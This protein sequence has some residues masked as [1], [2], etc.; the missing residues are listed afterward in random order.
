MFESGAGGDFAT[1][2]GGRTGAAYRLDGALDHSRQTY[3]HIK[4]DLYVRAS[5]SLKA[6]DARGG[7]ALY[8]EI[9]AKYPGDSDGHGALGACLFF[10]DKCQ[11]ASAEYQ[12]SIE[13]NPCPVLT[14]WRAQTN[15]YGADTR[16]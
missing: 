1:Y 16:L 9:I 3:D 2:I 4:S 13:L 15:G 11:E 6:G 14:P 8:R 7:E 10:L 5:R 12:Q